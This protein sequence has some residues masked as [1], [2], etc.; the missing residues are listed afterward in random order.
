M[1]RRHQLEVKVQVLT[2][3]LIEKVGDRYKLIGVNCDKAAKELNVT[4][5]TLKQD[6]PVSKKKN[7][8]VQGETELRKR[9]RLLEQLHIDAG[10]A[11]IL[12]EKAGAEYV[13][14]LRITSGSNNDVHD[15]ARLF[16]TIVA[17]YR[18]HS[19]YCPQVMALDFLE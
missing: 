9:I 16:K 6:N 18:V 15:L 12:M 17:R 3:A 2:R 4:L 19:V 10:W 13:V 14:L 11:T 8:R 5:Q 7:E 1:E